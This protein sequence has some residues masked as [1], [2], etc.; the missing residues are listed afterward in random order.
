[1][2]AGGRVEVGRAIGRKGKRGKCDEKKK[3]TAKFIPEI[4][5]SMRC[6]YVCVCEHSFLV[7]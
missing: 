7:K 6:A 5:E 3:Q 4:N 1:M 2:G